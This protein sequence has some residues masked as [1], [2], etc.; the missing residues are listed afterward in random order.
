MRKKI[1]AG[2]F[3]EIYLGIVLYALCI[4]AKNTRNNEEVAIK[5]VKINANTTSRNLD[6]L[7]TP[8]LYMKPR[9]LRCFKAQV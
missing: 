9:C 2:S 3:G 8:R 4:T 7:V 5:T 1:G 6:M